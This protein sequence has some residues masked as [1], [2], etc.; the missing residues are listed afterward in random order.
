MP[1]TC[2]KLS[3]QRELSTIK[4]SPNSPVDHSSCRVL[5]FTSPHATLSLHPRFPP[6]ALCTSCA[7]H[8]VLLFLRS[9]HSYLIIIQASHGLWIPPTHPIH[10]GSAEYSSASEEISWIHGL[11]V[12]SPLE[13][14]PPVDRDLVCLDFSCI[15]SV[16]PA[17]LGIW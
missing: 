6:E 13:R 1:L 8:L 2:I 4:S 15:P 14:K 10:S 17:V 3:I 9:S 7:F 5:P 16:S 12:C 11:L